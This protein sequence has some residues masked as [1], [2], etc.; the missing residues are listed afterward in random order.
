MNQQRKITAT[1]LALIITALG[2]APFLAQTKVEAPKN[3]YKLEEDVQLGRQAASEIERQ[4]PLLNDPVVQEY[5]IDVGR[6]LAEAIPQQYQYPQF[7]YSFKVADVKDLNAFALPGGFTYVNRG[8]IEAAKNEGE[9]AGVMA[10]EIS[11]VALRHGTAQVAKAR[12]YQTLGAIGQIFGAVIGGAA[13]G[14]IGVG[15]QIGAGLPILKFG[16]EYER[17]ADTLGAQIMARAG[18]DPRDLANMFRTIEQSGGS[19]GPE[20]LSSHPN[21]GNRY[22]AINREAQLLNVRDPI[23][24]TPEFNRV[25]ARLGGLPPARTMEEASRGGRSTGGSRPPRGRVA[26]PSSRS[27]VYT[28]NVYEIRVP[29]N[30]REIRDGDGVTYAPEGGYGDIQGRFVFTHGVQVGVTRAQS[31]DLRRATD[32]LIRA[33][34]Q[35]NP[36]LRQESD[37]ERGNID[38]QYALGVRLS[39]VSEVTRGEE[40]ILLY[41]TM[42]RNGDLFYMVAVAPS[43]EY[44]NYERTFF[45]VLR[46]IRL[47]G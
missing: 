29:D 15:S 24:N 36:D 39:N 35:G 45:N 2:A 27:R 21:P 44:Q 32:D 20:W 25:R 37:Y 19:G 16:R 13:G 7:R 40:A 17:Q 26:Y 33:F 43:R 42:L 28:G 5:I 34:Q 31:D 22:E 4:L 10:H 11:H 30:W 6:R 12:K 38:G 3:P 41:T 23:R 8:L 46:S 18:Y 14:A 9:L 1:I 47:N